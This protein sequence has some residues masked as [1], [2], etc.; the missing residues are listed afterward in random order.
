MP[1]YSLTAY[2][3]SIAAVVQY[4]WRL[5]IQSTAGDFL[6]ALDGGPAYGR[7]WIKI[8]QNSMPGEWQSLTAISA[9]VAASFQFHAHNGFVLSVQPLGLLIPI[10]NSELEDLPT[11]SDLTWEGAL[12]AGY[13]FR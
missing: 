9:R 8:E 1:G 13:R 12:L 3:M 10:W 6:I 4:D 5:G 2:A 11:D 7:A